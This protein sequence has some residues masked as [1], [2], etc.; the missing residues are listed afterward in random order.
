LVVDANC[1][2]LAGRIQPHTKFLDPGGVPFLIKNWILCGFC[3]YLMRSF[4]I[5]FHKYID[6]EW[7]G[8]SN[9]FYEI[10]N[11]W[12]EFAESFKLPPISYQFPALCMHIIIAGCSLKHYTYS[13]TNTF[14]WICNNKVMG[15]NLYFEL[16]MIT[17]KAM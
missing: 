7:C 2:Y 5:F 13:H 1:N 6:N 9:T 3:E 17:W 4:F 16:F 11:T 14:T 8:V 10:N 12:T 15:P